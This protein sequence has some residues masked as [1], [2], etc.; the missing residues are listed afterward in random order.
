MSNLDRRSHT[1][2]VQ[3]RVD[4]CTTSASARV[5]RHNWKAARFAEQLIRPRARARP[6]ACAGKTTK[7]PPKP[8]TDFRSELLKRHIQ[9]LTQKPHIPLAHR[10][11]L[12]DRIH[13]PRP[14][15]I[16]NLQPTNRDMILPL[17]VINQRVI[18]R[19][20]PR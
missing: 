5:E 12:R 4:A 14:K 13:R 20:P 6:R 7:Q 18:L 9:R 11:A 3:P 1:S 17:E 19:K 10:K 2:S 15:H 8:G 16:P